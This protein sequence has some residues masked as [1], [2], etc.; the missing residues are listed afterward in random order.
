MEN[1]KKAG[2]NIS[3]RGKLDKNKVMRGHTFQGEIR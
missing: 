1:Y 3:K 2:L